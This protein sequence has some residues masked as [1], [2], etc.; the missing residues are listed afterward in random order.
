M[1]EKLPASG[2]TLTE[3]LVVIVIIAMIIIWAANLDFRRLSQEQRV[4]IE[5]ISIANIFEE[6]RNNSL[7][8]RS[9]WN[10]WQTPDSWKIEFSTNGSGTIVSSYTVSGTDYPYANL[11]WNAPAFYEIQNIKCVSLD[12]PAWSEDILTW[13][14]TISFTGSLVDL[15]G[16]N[17]DA[18]EHKVLAIEFWNT[19]FS[20]IIR[21]NTLTGIIETD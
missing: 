3:I 21:F 16:T 18:P 6:I 7:I 17:C 9:V 10:P 5:S 19:R 13:T 14:G 15:S 1:Q 2:F 8:G 4:A 11:A 12:W 20:E